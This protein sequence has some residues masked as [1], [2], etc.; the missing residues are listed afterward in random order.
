MSVAEMSQLG[1][2]IA[3]L[4]RENSALRRDLSIAEDRQRTLLTI[5]RNTPAPIYFKDAELRYVLVN[6]CFEGLGHVSASDIRGKTDFDVFPPPIAKLFRS[7]DEDVIRAGTALEFEETLTLPDGEFTFITIKFPVNDSMGRLQAIG[8]F[9]TDITA[10][11]RSEREREA[12]I[13]ELRA[14]L[15]E[16]AVLRELLP[17]CAWCKQIRDDGG[18][19]RQLEEYL[20]VHSKLQFTHSI[21]PSCAD[22][23]CSETVEPREP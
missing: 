1:E 14:A 18:Y 8:G 16:I 5:I 12:L 20:E 7:Q 11:K 15:K 22:K 9:C 21:C 10:R 13:E 17:M 4:E 6:P 19:W 23:L 3:Q 2:R